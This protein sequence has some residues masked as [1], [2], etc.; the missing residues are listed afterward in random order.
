MKLRYSQIELLM[1]LYSLGLVSTE[2]LKMHG[3]S[4]QSARNMIKYGL[5]QFT[6]DGVGV[7]LTDRG[8]RFCSAL[9]RAI[10]SSTVIEPYNRQHIVKLASQI[11][12]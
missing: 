11:A 1:F 10:Q 3:Y 6:K 2:F 12:I 9:N 7:A 4:V 5:V 8:N